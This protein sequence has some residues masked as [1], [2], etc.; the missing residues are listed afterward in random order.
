MTDAELEEL[1]RNLESDRVERKASL[2]DGEK[3]RQAICAFA[4]DL[5]NHR[6]EG[7]VFIGV[8]DDGRCAGIEV[9]DALLLKLADV[10]DDGSLLPFPS[11]VVEKRQL[12][13]CE[14]AVVRVKPSEAPPVRYKGRTWV[15]I[16]PRRGL[17]TPEEERRLAE[18]RRAGDLPFDIQ[19]VSAASLADLDLE[20]FE[21]SYLPSALP[22]DVL[23]KN[24][25][26]LG[27]QLASMRF[28]TL[29]AEPR[30]T[31]LGLLAVGKM[32]TESL[33]G[34]YLQFL[35]LDGPELSDPI[36]DQK[37]IEGPLTDLI[38]RLDD[39]FRANI[40]TATDVRSAATEIQHP[41]YPF[42]AL[43]QIARNAILH[44]TYEG[45]N[46]PVRI[47]WF[48]DRVEIIS[49]GGPFG[50]VNRENFGRPGM[51]DYRNPHLAEAMHR[52]GF[53]QRFRTGIATAHKALQK[54]GNPPL[55]FRVDT[56]FTIAI[57]R[58]HHA[59]MHHRTSAESSMRGS[60]R[61]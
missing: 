56:N 15:R 12:A 10:R 31:I 50:R 35:R 53:V 49:P 38:R 26:T 45:T 13:G 34:A 3:V 17:A 41:D 47:N 19:P 42:E 5:P 20:F 11:M 29:E 22:L 48:S 4:N 7:V 51:T 18:K 28:A 25:R 39:V 36:K 6:R 57:L 61:P 60:A 37:R 8:H 21:E 23:E 9:T 46:S 33:P 44:R 1:I 30:P 43:Q 24:R 52:L 58:A 55:E 40:Q 27:E 2:S 32:P 16:G 59:S 54:N 14:L